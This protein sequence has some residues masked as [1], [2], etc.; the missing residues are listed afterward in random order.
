MPHEGE[1][2]REGN[3]RPAHEDGAM[4]WVSLAHTKRARVRRCRDR[5]RVLQNAHRR[6][7]A[8]FPGT[9]ILRLIEEVEMVAEVVME[10]PQVR[11]DARVEREDDLI[12]TIREGGFERVDVLVVMIPG[13]NQPFRERHH[14]PIGCE[15][16]NAVEEEVGSEV[17][18]RG[19]GD[20]GDGESI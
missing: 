18:H 20:D 16:P 5:C 11:A 13:A 15:Q 14:S 4:L 6:P 7:I 17:D 9:F 10:D 19:C 8:P 1:N 12:E 3:G 2:E